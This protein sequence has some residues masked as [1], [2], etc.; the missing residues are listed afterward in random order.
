MARGHIQ[1]GLLHVLLPGWYSKI[2]SLAGGVYY[3]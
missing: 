3:R 2:S 1:K